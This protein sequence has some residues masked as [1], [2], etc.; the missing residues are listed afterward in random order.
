MTL[1]AEHIEGDTVSSIREN[2]QIQ[3]PFGDGKISPIASEEV[4]RV[5]A[6]ILEDPGRH[7][8]KVYELTGPR[9]QDM[10]G[11]AEE[12][13]RALGHQITYVSVPWGPWRTQLENSGQLS[14]HALAH[15]A[16]MALLKHQNRYDRLTSDVEKVTGTPP[17]SV[18]DFVLR[19]A[20][21]YMAGSEKSRS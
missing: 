8:G 6:V 4:A 20:A 19:H 2:R 3:L 7:I 13:S 18:Y 21:M 12:F 17:L 10:N 15:L 9:S 16:T 1:I 5:I 14:P 11:V